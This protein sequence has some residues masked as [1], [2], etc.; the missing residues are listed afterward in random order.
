M[1]GK[2][3]KALSGLELSGLAGL[4]RA[5][6]FNMPLVAAVAQSYGHY[7]ALPKKYKAQLLGKESRV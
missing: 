3:H 1:A 2:R 7:L 6:V 4:Q 5:A